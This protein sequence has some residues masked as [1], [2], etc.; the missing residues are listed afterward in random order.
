MPMFTRREV[1]MARR[2]ISLLMLAFAS[3][4]LSACAELTGPQPERD[5]CAD[6]RG[7]GTC[8]SAGVYAG[9]GTR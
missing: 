5:L 1:P 3:F 8:V 9:S 2:H 6:S 7:A 4:A